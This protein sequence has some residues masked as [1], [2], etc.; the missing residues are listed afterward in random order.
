[1]TREEIEQVDIIVIGAGLTGLTAAYHLKE[2]GLKVQILECSKHVGGAIQTFHQGGFTFESGPNTGVVGSVEMAEILGLVP[3][4]R[5]IADPSAK[6]R[7]I[8]KNGQFYPLPSGAN[9]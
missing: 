9:S 6:K 8:L 2:L 4:L 5:L 7:L 1:M 3:D